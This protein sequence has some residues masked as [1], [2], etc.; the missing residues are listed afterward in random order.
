MNTI[1]STYVQSIGTLYNTRSLRFSDIFMDKY[2][3]VFDIEGKKKILEI[4]CGPGALAE[5]LFRWY[6][7]AQIS[8]ID[9]DSNFI[10][11]ANKQA[12]HIN[13]SE[14]DAIALPFGTE[15][16]DVTVSN[17]VAEHIDPE[18]FYSE[19]YRVLKE[20][21]VCLVLSARRGI[22]ISAPCIKEMSEFE[23]DVW[24]RVDKYCTE[25]N[26]KYDVCSY[27]QNEAEMPLCMEKYGFKNVSTEYITV[28][29]TP[30][31]PVYSKE[32]AHAMINANRQCAIDS[33]D[34]LLNIASGVV[35][36]SE[37]EELKLLVNA[38]YD[39][40]LELYDKGIKQWDTN[41]S[42]TMIMRG[43]KRRGE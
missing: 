20:N 7:N 37:V 19:Q 34:G 39:K 2:K 42:V 30:D 41:V 21:G 11:F 24:Q 28:N 6:P 5:S 12:S 38:K 13:F 43:V 25:V 26:K 35:S 40:R 33:V 1:W 27:P 29:L 8:A 14:G 16:F 10:E 31:N 4:G 17:T 18:K 36:C 32:M 15:S 3:D 22:N 23:K 9:R